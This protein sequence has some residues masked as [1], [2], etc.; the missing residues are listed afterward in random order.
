MQTC[1][2]EPVQA[3]PAREIVK[4]LNFVF[5]H[6]MGGNPCSFQNLIDR[7]NS[8]LPYYTDRYNETHPDITI[9]VNTLARC[10]PGYEDIGDWAE[11]IAGSINTHFA[12]KDNLILVGHSMGGKTALYATA[13][14]TGNISGRVAAVITINSPIKSMSRYYVPGGGPMADYC[15]TALLG[16]DRGV[17]NS[18]AFYDSSA[19]GL[20]VSQEKH[21]LAFISA[22]SYPVSPEFNRSGVDIFPRHMDDGI[23]PLTAQFADGADV[24]Y[25]GHQQHSDAGALDEISEKLVNHILLYVFGYPQEFSALARSGTIR[26]D[27]DWLLGTDTWTDIVGGV[28]SAN[29]TITHKNDSFFT[30]QEYEDIIG[31]CDEGDERSYTHV[32]LAS[33]PL[34]TAITGAA[35]LNAENVSDCRL[36]VTT[37]AAPLTTVEVD[38]TIFSAGIL[39]KETPRSFYNVE[40]TRG[41]PMAS[42]TGAGWWKDDPLNPVIWIMSEAQ[43]PF[44]WFEAEWSIYTNEYRTINIIETVPIRVITYE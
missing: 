11:N 44:R 40:I 16:S 22:E 23:V 9:K 1:L 18:L 42:I 2:A 19:D 24:I 21:W 33:T 36:S 26:H 27:A 25:Y 13:H 37:V 10:Y 14:N 32:H 8:M 5:L 7:M 15:R 41:T 35:W 28:V 12:S 4:E 38:W 3:A 34:L 20:K 6:G 29:G 31:T 43:S 17:C 39:P 30:F